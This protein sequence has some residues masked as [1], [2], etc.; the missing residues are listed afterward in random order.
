MVENKSRVDEDVTNFANPTCTQ[1]LAPYGHSLL[2]W[3]PSPLQACGESVP[4]VL[5]R[6]GLRAIEAEEPG[7]SQQLEWRQA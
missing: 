6:D 7:A 2:R 1:A 5:S 4:Y 3:C